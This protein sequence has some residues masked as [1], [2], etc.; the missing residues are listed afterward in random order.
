[1]AAN[2]NIY[3][4]LIAKRAGPTQRSPIALSDELIDWSATVE[5]AGADFA[6]PAL[7][8]LLE[9]AGLLDHAP[10]DVQR[11]LRYALAQNADAN[12]ELR[13]QCLEIGE[14]LAAAGLYA[15]L[16]KGACFLFED[17]PAAQDRMLRDIDL[18][19]PASALRQTRAVLVALGYKTWTAIV[20]EID[21]VHDPPLEH[22]E[23]RAS[24]EIHVELTPWV[25]YLRADEVLAQLLAVA[26]G[27]FMPAPLDRLVHNV[28]HA[29][30]A[31]GDFVGGALSLRD[32]LDIG[33]LMQKN[34]S[35]ADWSNLATTAQQRRFF[36]PLSGAL[37]KAAYISGATLP[38]P[39]CSDP[40]GRRHLQRCLLQ[41]RWPKLGIVMRKVGIL[42]R[43]T[44]WERDAYA[45]GLGRDR[46]LVANFLVNRRRLERIRA[47]LHRG[48]TFSE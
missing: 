45:L 1:M 44:A 34:I 24:V 2:G 37:H 40:G 38:E 9:D 14:A 19:V 29:Q 11:F 35:V 5:A 33:R 25:N 7:A 31:N 30:I 27:L 12:W 47:A 39:F 8:R 13:K 26:P 32:S 43:A 48:G 20:P 42:H 4:W 41:R 16:L 17:G 23:R 3:N 36:R 22:P 28:V 46:G 6:I 10:G 15:V 18:L 21:H